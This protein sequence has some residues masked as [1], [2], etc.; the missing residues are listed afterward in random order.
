[1]KNINQVFADNL[2]KQRKRLGLSQLQLGKMLSYSEKS[3]SK[4]E[5]GV[6]YI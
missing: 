2:K 3:V 5:A 1:M 6:S 4:W